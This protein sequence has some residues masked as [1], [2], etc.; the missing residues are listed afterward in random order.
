MMA[1]CSNP[2]QGQGSLHFKV[3]DFKQDPLVEEERLRAL[4]LEKEL[5]WKTIVVE[6]VD[7]FSEIESTVQKKCFA[8]HDAKT[9]T[10]IYGRV[11]TR[12]NP[13]YHHQQDGIKALDFSQKFPLIAKGNPSQIA[14][15]KAI[16]N[17]VLDRTMPIKAYTSVYRKRKINQTDEEKILAWTDPLIEKLEEFEKRFDV[18]QL[19]VN[20]QMTKVFEQ[21]CFRCHAN[22]NDRG[23]F[24]EMQ[25]VKKLVKGKFVNMQNPLDS[26]IYKLSVS[27]KMPPNPRDALEDQE[28]LLLGEWLER[29]SLENRNN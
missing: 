24:G 19:D 27:K 28:L 13:I 11:F 16:R 18:S 12:V 15:L 5:A 17:E 1:S 10:P 9:K 3:K 6:A 22:G 14:L 8:C 25:D 26:A 23:N 21:K 7:S 29:L 4:R 2:F 20:S